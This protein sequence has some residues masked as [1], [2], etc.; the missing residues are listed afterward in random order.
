[1]LGFV[2]IGT[3]NIQESSKFYDLI[4][5]ILGINKVLTTERYLG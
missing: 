1:M 2:T 5:P 4:L 3:N